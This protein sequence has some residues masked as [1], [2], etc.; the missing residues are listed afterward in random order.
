MG[1][2]R[3]HRPNPIHAELSRPILCSTWNPAKTLYMFWPPRRS[4]STAHTPNTWPTILHRVRFIKRMALPSNV[5][6]NGSS[7][8]T[9]I[10]S[11]SLVAQRNSPANFIVIYPDMALVLNNN[12]NM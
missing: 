4:H 3:G 1:D 12:I 10:V 11:L 7:K 6:K 9:G 8:G 2:K 5:T